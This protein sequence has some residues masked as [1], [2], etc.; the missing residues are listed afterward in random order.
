M[1]PGLGSA[2]LEEG[3]GQAR[4]G[5]RRTSSFPLAESGEGI[6]QAEG[7]ARNSTGNSE[8]WE[9]LEQGD[10]RGRGGEVRAV[11]V[12]PRKWGPHPKRPSFL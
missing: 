12:T 2:G 5:A 3:G 1:A 7:T 9:W 10:R 8:N 6:F 11:R 4:V